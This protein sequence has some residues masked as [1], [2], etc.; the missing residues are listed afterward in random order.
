MP[1]PMPRLK[2]GA[3]ERFEMVRPQRAEIFALP[4]LGR[5]SRLKTPTFR[6]FTFH[7]SPPRLARLARPPQALP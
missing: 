3:E 1:Y 5:A 2:S 7:Q 6:S 4:T